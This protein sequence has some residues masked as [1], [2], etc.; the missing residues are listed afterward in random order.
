LTIELHRA[1]VVFY[2][3]KGEYTGKLR[4][5]VIVQRN[6]SLRDSPSI[7]LCGITSDPMPSHAG[8]VP[9]SPSSENG[10]D[11]PSYVMID[12][13]VSISRGRI[14]H[15]LGRLSEDEIDQVDIALRRWLD[16]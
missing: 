14:R 13:I 5:G 9:L 2:G 11:R 8:R 7:T 3:E 15:Q 4:P 16:L 6:A 1:D 10:L 12:K